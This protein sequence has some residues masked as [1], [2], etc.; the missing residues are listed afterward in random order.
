MHGQMKKLIEASYLT[1]ENASDYRTILRYFYL[2]HERMRDFISPEE[3]LGYMRSLP[4]YEQYEEEALLVQLA[5]LVKWKNLNARQDMTNAKTI[6]EYKKKRFRYQ[7]TPYTI[8]IER[9]VDTLERKSGESFGGSLEKSQFDRLLE[10]VNR[11]ESEL[12]DGLVKSS[13]TYMLLWED[14]L[15]YFRTIRTSTADY[16]AYINSEQTDQRMQ[17]EAFLVYKNQFTTY[18]RDFIVSLQK[19]SFQISDQL[20]RMGQGEVSPFFDKLAEYRRQIPRLEEIGEETVLEWYQEFHDFWRVMRSWFIGSESQSSELEMLQLQTNEMIRR[21][22][23][24]VQR[25]SER[26]HSFHSRKKDYLHL[27]KL[28][29]EGASLEDAH[30]LSAVVFGSMTIRHLKIEEDSTENMHADIWEEEPVVL[31]VKPRIREYKD[32]TKP[33][34]MVSNEGKKKALFE[35][36]LAEMAEE[37]EVVRELFTEETLMLSEMGEVRPFVRKLILSWIGKGLTS[38]DGVIKTDYGFTLKVTVDRERTT[39]L[40]SEDG[41]MKMPD[42][43][44]EMKGGT[45]LGNKNERGV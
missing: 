15:Q 16:I 45:G 28:F 4:H 12:K 21:I 29:S 20:E 42:V 3:V 37:R 9:M 31:T 44:F 27:A 23:R 11:L 33:G 30:K 17:S 13:E 2:Q 43:M 14:L 25:M 41:I 24:S 5:Q 22:T 35:E 1:A 38:K 18:L 8:E 26:H 36:H 6:E 34:A 10:A 39:L 40:R 7:P 19:T 32:K